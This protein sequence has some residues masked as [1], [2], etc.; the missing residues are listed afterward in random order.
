MPTAQK[1]MFIPPGQDI[2]AVARQQI[3]SDRDRFH[4]AVDLTVTH[5]GKPRHQKQWKKSFKRELL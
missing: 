4:W 5:N 1:H 2:E 3:R